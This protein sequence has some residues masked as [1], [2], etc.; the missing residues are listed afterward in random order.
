MSLKSWWKRVIPPETRTAIG[1]NLISAI[2]PLL[3]KTW[4]ITDENRAAVED[5][6]AANRGV[7]MVTWHGR[8][9]V[10]FTVMM[11]RGCHALVSL[12][13]DGELLAGVLKR[14]GWGLIRGSSARVA[15]AALKRAN[16]VLAEPGAMLAFTPDGPRVPCG[17]AQPGM[18]FLARKTGKPLYPVGIAATPRVLLRSWDRFLIPLPFARCHFIYG[19]PIHVGADEDLNAATLRVQTAISALEARAEAFLGSTPLPAFYRPMN[20]DLLAGEPAPDSSAGN[21]ALSDRGIG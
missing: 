14:L 11:H 15:V 1:V 4:R 18:I 2:L 21:A 7:I 12:S 5:S 9:L 20:A 3:H 6:L 13:N 16:T 17:V 8:C 10:P 19:D